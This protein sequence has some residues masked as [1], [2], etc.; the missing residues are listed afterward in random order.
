[1]LKAERGLTLAERV[2]RT[3]E[4]VQRLCS[5]VEF[6]SNNIKNI[7]KQVEAL[8]NPPQVSASETEEE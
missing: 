4:A 6:L 5:E 7:Q 8:L 1:M 2:R 3:E